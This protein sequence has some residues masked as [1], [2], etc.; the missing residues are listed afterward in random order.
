MKALDVK[1]IA[2]D[3]GMSSE[4]NELLLLGLGT[5]GCVSLKEASEG[6]ICHGL[7]SGYSLTMWIDS[8][9]S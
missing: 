7:D 5:K 3:R 4:D 9:N 6:M 8:P 2:G 1:E